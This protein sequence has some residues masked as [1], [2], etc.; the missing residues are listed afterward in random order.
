MIVEFFKVVLCA[1]LKHYTFSLFI[2]GPKNSI[3]IFKTS[4]KPFAYLNVQIRTVTVQLVIKTLTSVKYGGYFSI[5]FSLFISFKTCN[6]MLVLRV[7]SFNFRN[8]AKGFHEMIYWKKSTK[9]HNKP[10]FYQ[11]DPEI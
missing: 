11:V 4:Y 8:D 1:G 5:Q 3:Q 7:I 10:P 9:L 2:I 6:R